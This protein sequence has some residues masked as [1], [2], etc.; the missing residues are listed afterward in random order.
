MSALGRTR[1]LRLGPFTPRDGEIR[2]GFE[3]R[4]DEVTFFVADSG[5]GVPA[6]QAEHIFERFV[7]SRTS[8]AGLGLGLFIADRLVDAHGGRLWF[9]SAGARGTVFRFTLERAPGPR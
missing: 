1:R 4:D 6:E 8:S 3:S 2:V 7:G 9:E 5:P